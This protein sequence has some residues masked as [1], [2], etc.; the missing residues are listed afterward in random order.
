MPEDKAYP[1][2]T[3]IRVDED[4]NTWVEEFQL[5][6]GPRRWRVISA[7]GDDVAMVLVPSGFTPHQIFRERIL[8]IY[9]DEFD[10]ERVQIR[11]LER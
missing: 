7:S 10:V 2:L 4:G 8:G 3:D 11:R 9:P 6:E 1:A 5:E